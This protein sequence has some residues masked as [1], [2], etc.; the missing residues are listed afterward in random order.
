MGSKAFIIRKE[1]S[2]FEE[3]T[4][5]LPTLFADTGTIMQDNRNIIKKIVT[6]HGI[7]V[8]KDFAGMYFFNRIAY[9]F[10]RKSK[11]ERSF[12]NSGILNERGILTPPH[13][14]WINFYQSGL[15]TRSYFVSMFSPLKT[16]RQAFESGFINETNRA[17]FI[18]DLALFTKKLHD[19]EIYHKDFSAGNILVNLKDGGIGYEFSLLDLNRVRFRTVGFKDGLR[20]FITLE[21]TPEVI[22][23]LITE[24]AKL[25]NRTPGEAIKMYWNFKTRSSSLRRL[26]K[27][28]RSYTLTPLERM[29]NTDKTALNV[30]KKT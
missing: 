29:V 7:V 4:L 27:T 15:L 14:S 6:P 16:F 13:V 20:N 25:S 30:G 23:E 10:F 3:F 9:S 12:I 2:E 17:G 11:A 21:T 26:R 22:N 24:Y 28:I 1:F 8:V 19:S 18:H 5:N